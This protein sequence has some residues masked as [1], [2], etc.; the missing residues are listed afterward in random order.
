MVILE[1]EADTGLGMQE[2]DCEVMPMR[3]KG[4]ER[5]TAQVRPSESSASLLSVNGKY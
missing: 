4:A 2:V 5:R 3:N 1:A